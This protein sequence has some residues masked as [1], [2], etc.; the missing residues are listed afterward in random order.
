MSGAHRPVTLVFATERTE[1]ALREALFANRTVAW[2]GNYLAGSEKLLS[3]IFKASVSV[4]ADFAEEA[5]K[6]KI[7][8]VK[9]LS[10]I[11]F[12][13]ASSDG[14]LIKIPAYSESRVNIPKN[15]DMRFEVINLMITAT[16]NLEIEFHVTK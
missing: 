4:V 12:K 10:D 14:T 11:S 6:D 2:F 9:N 5:Q 8:N 16:K 7:Y 3:A 15:S 1:A 13:L